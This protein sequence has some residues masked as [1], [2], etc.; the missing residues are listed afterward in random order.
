MSHLLCLTQSISAHV[1]NVSRSTVRSFAKITENMS[2]K[3]VVES[4]LKK[5]SIRCQ[6]EP[7][8]EL[9]GEKILKTGSVPLRSEIKQDR[10]SLSLQCVFLR[11]I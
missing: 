10:Q 9:R 11:V 2:R 8:R 5:K 4:F 7:C 3:K 6:R 1:R